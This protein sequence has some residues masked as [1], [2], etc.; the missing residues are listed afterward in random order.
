MRKALATVVLPVFLTF[1]M[2]CP[3]MQESSVAGRPN[4]TV[5]TV[6]AADIRP[7]SFEMSGLS[8]VVFAKAKSGFEKLK[9]ANPALKPYLTIVDL[10]QSSNSKRM[11]IIDMETGELVMQT[12]AAHGR[13]SG[14]EYATA[15]SNTPNSYM[16]SPGFYLTGQTYN[17]KH[18]LS[19]QLQGLEK[20][21]NDRAAERAIV[22]H[23]ASYVSEDFIRKNGRLGRSQ[24]CPAVSEEMCEPIINL[25]KDGSCIYIHARK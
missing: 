2:L 5:K 18:G 21:I 23:G 22:L 13:N 16:S 10:S 14:Q 24:G 3:V 4:E 11:F 8:D 15:F 1:L 6:T 25:I 20:G 7:V 17:G 9:S 19:L 12:Y